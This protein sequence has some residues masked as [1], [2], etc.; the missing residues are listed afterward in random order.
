MSYPVIYERVLLVNIEQSHGCW[1]MLELCASRRSM[2]NMFIFL[3][4]PCVW[5]K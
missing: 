3:L 5:S 2:T 4:L 1:W